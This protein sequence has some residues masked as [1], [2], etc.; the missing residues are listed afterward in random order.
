MNRTANIRRTVVAIF[1]LT[2]LGA[3]LQLVK[4]TTPS[5]AEQGGKV[6]TGG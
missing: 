2:M 4:P 5:V 6:G 3:G 1:A